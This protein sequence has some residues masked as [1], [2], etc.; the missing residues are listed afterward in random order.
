MYSFIC[1]RNSF[2]C[3]FELPE[4]ANFSNNVILLSF[5]LDSK[6]CTQQDVSVCCR[7]YFFPVKIL[8]HQRFSRHQ[9]V[10]RVSSANDSLETM[11]LQLIVLWTTCR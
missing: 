3:D 4:D 6:F 9:G 8:F 10:D 1:R 7:C 2:I 11:L 5:I